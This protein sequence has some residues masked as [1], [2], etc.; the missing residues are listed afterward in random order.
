MQDVSYFCY[1]PL[2]EMTGATTVS[3]LL[4]L[5]GDLNN[6]TRGETCTQIR[7][8]VTEREASCR[9]TFMPC[10]VS[11]VLYLTWRDLSWSPV[12]SECWRTSQGQ[13][14]STKLVRCIHQGQEI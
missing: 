13:T 11:E 9:T 2:L 1:I 14:H 8:R 10:L 3:I 12:L 6:I 5:H 4:C 7:T